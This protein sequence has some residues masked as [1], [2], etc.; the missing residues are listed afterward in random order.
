MKSLLNLNITVK[1]LLVNILIVAIVTSIILVVRASFDSL[2]ES[3][4]TIINEKITAVIENA[5][6][7]RELNRV[8]TT[9][10]SLINTLNEDEEEFEARSQLLVETVNRIIQDSEEKQLQRSLETYLQQ[11]RTVFTHTRKIHTVS[12]QLQ[13]INHDLSL[14]LNSV[15]EIIAEKMIMLAM[16]EED[17]LNVDQ[18]NTLIPGFRET[19]LQI[20]VKINTMRQEH[21][22]RF[23]AAQKHNETVSAEDV[24]PA[25]FLLIDDLILRF[26]SLQTS[27][28]DIAELGQQLIEKTQRY[29]NTIVDYHEALAQF[30]GQV[31]QV[32]DAQDNVLSNMNEIDKQTNET[33]GRIRQD[34]AN[35]I[36]SSKDII[37]LLSGVV[38]IVLIMSLFVIRWMVRPLVTLSVTAT[39]LADGDIDCTVEEVPY[40][41]EIGKLSRAFKKLIQYFREMAH[42]AT[43]ISQGNLGLDIHPRSDKDVFGNQFQRMVV[44]L[45][46]I[47]GIADSVSQGDLRS[48]VQLQ[49]SKDQLGTAF[50]QMHK[51]LVTLISGIRGAVEYISSVSTQVLNTSEKNAEALQQI[52][53]A[54]EVTSSAM[55][56]VNASAEEARINIEHL[57]SSVEDTSS[58]ISQMSNSIKHIADN[59]RKLSRFAEDTSKTVSTIVSSLERVADQADNSKTLAE[60]TT[61]DA[62]AG[63][64]F[65]EQMMTRM[66]KISE[67][68]DNISSIILR[69][70]SR[71]KEIGTILDVIN[72]VAEQTSL[73]S[74]NAS[75]IAAQAGEH[76]RGFAVVADEIK[77]LAVR[78]G[79]STKEIAKIVEAVQRDSSDA[80]KGIE[81]GQQEVDQG[82]QVAREASQALNK[83]GDSVKNSSS[84][85]VE[86]ADLVREQTTASTH[87]ADSV[88]GVN[89]MINEITGATEEQEKNSTQLLNIIE[90]MQSLTTQ[91]LRATQEQQRS[92][93]HVGELMSDVTTLVNQNT[94]TVK[95]LALLANELASQAEHLK[96]Q[97]KRFIIPEKDSSTRIIQEK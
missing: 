52:G 27:D 73:L 28:E 31:K 19:L 91:V 60:A 13:T 71:S 59:S 34:V 20:T 85:A 74:L 15:E 2:Q 1:L 26:R 42:T 89:T 84:V 3:F 33:T 97:V 70:E 21:A 23:E 16:E 25:L 39:Q 48:Q 6:R 87:I 54:A 78:V 57:S 53:T 55:Q 50:K 29:Q 40:H 88:R 94:P 41:D 9:T 77:E 45:K 11:L 58:F 81:E 56:Q 80:A 10:N 68:T 18:I 92:T 64:Q 76:G 90:N 24:H 51:G 37:F 67:V 49:T 5:Q 8:F 44:Y 79:T 66:S 12:Q 22:A 86:I 47:G 75:I 14:L 82:V 69:L 62:M 63:Q 32:H 93:L 7:G 61:K 96:Q 17:T 83:I 38:L 72:E 36:G 4:T 95:Q 46:D 30:H 43:E 35:M 65:V